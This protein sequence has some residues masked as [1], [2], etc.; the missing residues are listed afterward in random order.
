MRRTCS[1]SPTVTVRLGLGDEEVVARAH[2]EVRGDEERR[3]GRADLEPSHV[4]AVVV[5]D[6][7][8]GSDQRRPPAADQTFRAKSDAAI[9]A[10]EPTDDE[11]AV[12]HLSIAR[13]VGE[14][15]AAAAEKECPIV[16]PASV[17]AGQ[18]GDTA[19]EF[20]DLEIRGHQE[21]ALHALHGHRAPA[22]W[23]GRR[24]A[25]LGSGAKRREDDEEARGC[26]PRAGA[27][28]HECP[29][30]RLEPD[31]PHDLTHR[32]LRLTLIGVVSPGRT[33]IVE[34]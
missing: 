25:A 10:G 19:V 4:A 5:E 16:E 17:R 7:A 30:I 3:A 21:P 24:R 22:G 26:G 9:G 33:V 1:V 14:P 29:V 2:G 15:V 8:E 34:E 23:R 20:G 31:A 18:S 13:S 28:P 6:V 32:V 27:S 11:P 12:G